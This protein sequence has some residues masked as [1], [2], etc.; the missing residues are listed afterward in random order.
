MAEPQKAPAPTVLDLD[1]AKLTDVGRA[2]PHNEDYVD[3]KIPPDAREL[4]YKGSLFV[5]ADGM[6][7]HQAGEVASRGAVETAIEHYYG[8]TGRDVPTSLVRAV[9]AA[10]KRVYE[11]SQADPTKAGMGTTMV[12]AA[13]VGRRVYVANVGDS[14]AYLINRQGIVQITEDHSWVEEQVRAGL[15]T[16]EQARKHPQRNLV[17]RALGSKP[18]VEVDLFE[19]E[20]STG[21]KLL[22]CSDGLT[23]RVPDADIAAMVQQYPAGE[24][25]RRLVAEANERGGNDNITVLIVAAQQESATVKAPVMAAPGQQARRRLPLV[26]ILTVLLALVLV[27]VAAFW[28][29]NSGLL[30]GADE[31][32]T[33]SPVATTASPLPTATEGAVPFDTET[34]TPTVEPTSTLAAVTETPTAT[35]TP[36]PT[37]TSAPTATETATPTATQTSTATATQE[38]PTP[39]DTSPP[40][41]PQA[42][43]TLGQPEV[44]VDLSG[45][46]TFT[47]TTH[48]ALEQGEAFQLVIWRAD[49]TAAPPPSF[50]HESPLLQEESYKYNLDNFLSQDDV[51][52]EFLWSVRLVSTDDGEPL[53][54]TA[55]ARSF[56]YGPEGGP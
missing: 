31:T 54:D 11:Q 38:S 53:T 8:D 37:D 18:A 4:A 1:V 10:N 36:A 26:P 50:L 23:G 35:Q 29:W 42:P 52:Q 15:L 12:A 45:V 39:T 14:R 28:A 13:V 44:G 17:T 3:C 48:R 5:V 6:G 34:A 19:G 41:L 9:R 21:D 43:L 33:P 24:A 46:V 56:L 49:E 40:G 47:W 16:E 30:G 20:I 22:L 27:A 51:G 32:A 7:G 55:P 2:R 25:A